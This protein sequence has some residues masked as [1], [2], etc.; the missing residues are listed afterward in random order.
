MAEGYNAATCGPNGASSFDRLRNEV[1]G[2]HFE[3]CLMEIHS[4]SDQALIGVDFNRNLDD[5]AL[6][7][8]DGLH[9]GLRQCSSVPGP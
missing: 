2:F 7:T 8:G 4:I 5:Q 6:I 9:Y 1:H 3:M